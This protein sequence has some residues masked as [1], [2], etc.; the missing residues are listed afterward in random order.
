MKLRQF[1]SK[2][3]KQIRRS[4]VDM[5]FCLNNIILSGKS[6]IQNANFN[7]SKETVT[8]MLKNIEEYEEFYKK[9]V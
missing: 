2:L 4:Y 9:E 8:N 5:E 7:N 3:N 6:E 1:V